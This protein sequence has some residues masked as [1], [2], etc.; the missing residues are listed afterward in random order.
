MSWVR[1]NLRK[2]ISAPIVQVP[3]TILPAYVPSEIVPNIQAPSTTQNDIW[4]PA[5][6]MILHSA[7]E[8]INQQLTKLPLEES[9]IWIGLLQ[10]LRYS[11][12]CPRCKKHY[13]EYVATNPIRINTI[14][15]WLYKLHEQVNARTKKPS[16]PIEE[17]SSYKA[18]FNFTEK[19]TV[20]HEQ[21]MAAV[22]KGWTSH[23]DAIRTLRF[24]EEMKCFYNFP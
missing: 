20:L 16:Y 19:Y 2:R 14:Y 23:T 10:S 3:Q 8:R 22:K 9:R 1:S 4:G 21:I 18:P 13:S 24:L 7:C 12:P 17:L 5:L 11:L 6:W 15:L